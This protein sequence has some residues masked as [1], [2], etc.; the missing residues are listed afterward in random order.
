M[1]LWNLQREIVQNPVVLRLKREKQALQ[2]IRQFFIRCYDPE[3]KYHAIEQIYASLTVGQAM[4]FCRTKATARD[5]NIR[6]ANQGHSVR[7]LTGALDI[8]QRATIIN[9]FR[10]GVFRVLI[11]TNVTARGKLIISIL[12]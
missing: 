1:K 9:T 4:I 11:S 12:L 10:E 3:Q 2:N 8:E 5:L 7:E 6:M